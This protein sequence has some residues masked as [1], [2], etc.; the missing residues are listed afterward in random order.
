MEHQSGL[1]ASKA[2]MLIYT[3]TSASMIDRKAGSIG[4]CQHIQYEMNQVVLRQ[5]VS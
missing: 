1:I 2:I 5:P 4:R 3:T